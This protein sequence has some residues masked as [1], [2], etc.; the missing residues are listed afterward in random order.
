MMLK[1]KPDGAKLFAINTKFLFL[2]INT[3]TDKIEIIEKMP[4]AN[5][6]EGT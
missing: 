1:I 6:A 5:H 3:R 2:N 4:S